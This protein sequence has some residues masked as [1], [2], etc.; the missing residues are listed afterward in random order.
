MLKEG[1]IR[2]FSRSTSEPVV[3]REGVALKEDPLVC[4]LL[5]GKE[6]PASRLYNKKDSLPISIRNR[7][8]VWLS[9]G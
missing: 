3:E 4:L 9:N 1:S 7:F 5:F 6:V 8:L 2:G